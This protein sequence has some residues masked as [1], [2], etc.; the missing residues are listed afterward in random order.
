MDSNT[1]LLATTFSDAT[2]MTLDASIVFGT[3]TY[4]VS[5]AAFSLSL[6]G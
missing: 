1:D 2:D 6:Y 5:P 3:C 4:D